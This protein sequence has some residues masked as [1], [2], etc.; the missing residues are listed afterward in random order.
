MLQGR[1]KAP[2]IFYYYTLLTEYHT[3]VHSPL[4]QLL[5]V[6]TSQQY[7]YYLLHIYYIYFS[8]SQFSFNRNPIKTICYQIKYDKVMLLLCVQYFFFKQI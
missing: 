1:E 2:K 8:P 7:I 4:S 6:H 5:F 3:Y